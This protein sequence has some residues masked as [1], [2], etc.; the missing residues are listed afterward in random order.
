MCNIWRKKCLLW[1]V[2]Y[3]VCYSC[4]NSLKLLL[5]SDRW[6]L[7]IVCCR[8]LL[9]A[10]L[11]LSRT[12]SSMQMLSRLHFSRVMTKQMSHHYVLPFSYVTV[13]L[14]CYD[15]YFIVLSHG[16]RA[17]TLYSRVRSTAMT[18]D[19]RLVESRVNSASAIVK[20]RGIEKE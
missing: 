9:E 1:H 16:S 5:I 20:V 7:I 19:N 8:K 17:L 11:R 14:L 2:V 18:R 12:L 15:I 4:E 6:R 10:T 13:L 3:S